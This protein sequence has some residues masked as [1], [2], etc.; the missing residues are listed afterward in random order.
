MSFDREP[1]VSMNPALIRE[2]RMYVRSIGQRLDEGRGIWFVGGV[3][4]GKTTLAMLISK[5]AMAGGP[6]GRHLFA[7]AT[8][9]AA[10]GHL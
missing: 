4:T 9:R 5:A 7:A 10:A 1:V 8:A 2:V 3:G 6:D